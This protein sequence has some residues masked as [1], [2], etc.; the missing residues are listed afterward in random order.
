[1]VREVLRSKWTQLSTPS[2]TNGANGHDHLPTPNSTSDTIALTPNKTLPYRGG[3]KGGKGKR[4]KG[5]SAKKRA[6]K[7]AAEE[8]WDGIL[9]GMLERDERTL[10][11]P[12]GKAPD[13]ETTEQITGKVVVTDTRDKSGNRELVDAK[14]L[15]CSA[16][17][18]ASDEGEEEEAG[19]IK[20]VHVESAKTEEDV[21]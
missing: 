9:E 7:G 6:L 2:L 17:L 20:K 15:F 10:V 8:E 11:L 16:P 13:E 5:T 12:E 1:M 21:I 18:K 14:C 3:K 19:E 4:G